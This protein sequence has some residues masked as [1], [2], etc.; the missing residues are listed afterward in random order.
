[1][2]EG[3]E[4]FKYHGS[5]GN[6]PKPPIDKGVI[7]RQAFEEACR[8]LMQYLSENHNPHTRVI[9][10]SGC[11]EMLEGLQSFNTT[12]FFSNQKKNW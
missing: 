1:M 2:L 4:M 12:E 6:C 7:K 9:V 11:S 3:E 5:L 8:P 10:D